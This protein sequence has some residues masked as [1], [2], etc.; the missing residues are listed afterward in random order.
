MLECGVVD[1][2]F[3]TRAP[4]LVEGPEPSLLEGA[5]LPTPVQLRLLSLLKEEEFLFARYGV[6][7]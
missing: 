5:T 6:G 4:V 2:L 1:E 7:A 3:L